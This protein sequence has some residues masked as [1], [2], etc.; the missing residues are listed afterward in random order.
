MA[1]RSLTLKGFNFNE[2]FLTDWLKKRFR[3]WHD[4]N[5]KKR[6]MGKSGRLRNGIAWWFA[7]PQMKDPD[8]QWIMLCFDSPF[9]R[10]CQFMAS[11]GSVSLDWIQQ[12]F[13]LGRE[14]FDEDLA[15][16]GFQLA[17]ANDPDAFFVK[18]LK[19]KRA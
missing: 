5:N 8:N 4:Q 7:E 15:R 11:R 18:F 14:L 19:E 17:S 16:H 2:D 9:T 10:N 6:L 12:Q 13:D 1:T 3:L